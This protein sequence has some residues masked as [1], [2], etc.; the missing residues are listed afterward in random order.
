[1][2]T[3]IHAF[4]SITTPLILVLTRCIIGECASVF[5]YLLV[6]MRRKGKTLHP[7]GV[8]NGVF[9]PRHEDSIDCMNDTV[10]TD[11]IGRV[12]CPARVVV[13]LADQ[14]LIRIDLA[15]FVLAFQFV[16]TQSFEFAHQLVRVEILGNNV[17]FDDFLC[18][19]SVEILNSGVGRSEDSKRTI[20]SKKFCTF[21]LIDGG[22]ER[23]K[24]V[25]SLD[26]RGLSVLQS[27]EVTVTDGRPFHIP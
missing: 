14:G 1:M 17:S 9:E 22:L 12:W 25:V 4:P 26:I 21:G 10:F 27:S 11:D 19:N 7:L 16:P 6:K 20:P 18:Q 3:P 13:K 5:E 24:V 8:R 15:K 2:Y 23:I